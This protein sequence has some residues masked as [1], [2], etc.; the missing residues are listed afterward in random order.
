MFEY[1]KL[2]STK[3]RFMRCT[4]AARKHLIDY[5]ILFGTYHTHAHTD[6]VVVL[7][8]FVFIVFWYSLRPIQAHRNRAQF[9]LGCVQ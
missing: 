1:V 6:V 2:A 7:R 9:L 5:G 4:V 8:S 3:V